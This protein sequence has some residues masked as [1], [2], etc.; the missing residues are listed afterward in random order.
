MDRIRS[1]DFKW[2]EMREAFFDGFERSLVAYI[3]AG[4]S[5]IVE[6]IM[7]TPEWMRRMVRL[8]QGYDVF[9]VGVRCSLAELERRELARGDRPIG[10]A[11]RDHHTIHE[12]CTYDAEL[13]GMLLP[14]VNAAKLISLWQ[15]RQRPS[16]FER[17]A[18]A[19]E[20][21]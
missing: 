7:E 12:Y 18:N 15:T 10:D 4:N 20:A 5:L 6:Y 14:D 2:L 19:V 9:F 17:M 1:G 21:S 13:D 16:A 8:L 11:R 3:Q